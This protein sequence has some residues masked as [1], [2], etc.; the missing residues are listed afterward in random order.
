MGGRRRVVKRTTR[1]D[2][3]ISSPLTIDKFLFSDR[4]Y[5]VVSLCRLAFLFQILAVLIQSIAALPIILLAAIW[6]S[7]W[8]MKNAER[9]AIASF[10]V[11]FII[12]FGIALLQTG[13]ET[14]CFLDN[15]AR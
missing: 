3:K 11:Y 10:V 9:A 12:F 6:H 7:P 1:G 14:P 8:D 4:F 13:R 2:N 5:S 15:F